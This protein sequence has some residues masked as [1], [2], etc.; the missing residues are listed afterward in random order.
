[1]QLAYRSFQLVNSLY[2]T[3][4]LLSTQGTVDVA[5]TVDPA[6]KSV[7]TL[8]VNYNW[9][10]LPITNETVTVSLK[11]LACMVRLCTF[12]CMGLCVLACVDVL[13]CAHACSRPKSRSRKLTHSTP[14]L[15]L[16]G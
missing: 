3:T 16:R 10:Q 15:K 14:M 2:S 5:V 12:V 7:N 6:S 4:A 11:G 9:D 13:S 8:L 1:M